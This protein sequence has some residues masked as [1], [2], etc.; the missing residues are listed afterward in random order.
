M[1]DLVPA[2]VIEGV[3]VAVQLALEGEPSPQRNRLT[4]G[5][6]SLRVPEELDLRAIYASETLD[7]RLFSQ[8]AQYVGPFRLALPHRIPSPWPQGRGLPRVRRTV[9]VHPLMRPGQAHLALFAIQHLGELLIETFL[10]LGILHRRQLLQDLELLGRLGGKDPL[11]LGQI[12]KDIAGGESYGD[13]QRVRAPQL[14]WLPRGLGQRRK[15]RVGDD[16]AHCL[17]DVT[18]TEAQ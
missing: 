8:G 10:H 2:A 4:D 3:G 6:L 15:V 7:S 12:S 5:V 18:H 1:V 14:E 13:V 17:T 16:S 9:L 11:D